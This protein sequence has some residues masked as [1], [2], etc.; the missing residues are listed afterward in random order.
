MDG[1]SAAAS[2]LA[3]IDMSVKVASLLFQYS[4]EVKNAKEDIGRVQ[5][6]VD[7]L[8]NASES[9]RQL[10]QGPNGAKL[11]ASQKLLAALHDSLSQ[12]G[13]LKQRLEPRKTRK[14]MSSFGIRALKWPFDSKDIEKVVQDLGTCTQTISLSLQVDQ[15]YAVPSLCPKLTRLT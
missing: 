8:T 13:R 7:S 10:L 5:R 1:V 15:M 11:Q 4:K 3:V 14:V 12:L 6:Q 2:V 9:V